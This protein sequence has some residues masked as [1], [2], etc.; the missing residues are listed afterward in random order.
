MNFVRFAI[1]FFNM[2]RKVLS[3]V[4]AVILFKRGDVYLISPHLTNKVNN[5]NLVVYGDDYKYLFD[6]ENLTSFD[7][8]MLHNK[9]LFLFI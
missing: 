9:S 5:Y 7:I 2:Y 4:A 6:I 3:L 8:R 1:C